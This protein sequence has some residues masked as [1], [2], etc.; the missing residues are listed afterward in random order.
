[1]EYNDYN[2][3]IKNIILTTAFAFLLPVFSFAQSVEL[4]ETEL[5]NLENT[6]IRSYNSYGV[7]V[8]DFKITDIQNADEIAYWKIR[9]TCDQG[10]DL[11]VPENILDNNCNQAVNFEN[12]LESNQFSIVYRNNNSDNDTVKFAIKLKAY[13][14]QGDWLH[15]ETESF[16]WR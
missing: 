9:T 8:F 16:T 1:M 2:M 10:I 4:P 3:N 15:T 12:F 14:S 7:S 13:N 6:G 11:W 5:F